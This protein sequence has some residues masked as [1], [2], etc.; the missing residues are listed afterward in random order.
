MN[1]NQRAETFLERFIAREWRCSVCWMRCEKSLSKSSWITESIKF[2][3]KLARS[4]VRVNYRG[5]SFRSSLSS[6]SHLIVREHNPCANGYQFVLLL[7]FDSFFIKHKSRLSKWVRKIDDGE[8]F[9]LFLFFSIRFDEK[10]S[11]SAPQSTSLFH[12]L[13]SACSD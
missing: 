2:Q 5:C 3:L 6:I 4:I 1:I 10:S 9:A 11:L 13:P 12:L 8:S 7:W